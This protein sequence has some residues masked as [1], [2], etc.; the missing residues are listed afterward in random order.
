MNFHGIVGISA[1]ECIFATTGTKMSA[2]DSRSAGLRFRC[3]CNKLMCINGVRNRTGE[4]LFWRKF[5]AMKIHFI[6]IGGSAMHNLA[7]ALSREGHEVSGSDDEIFEPSKGRLAREGILPEKVGWDP[8]RIH[9]GLDAVILGM[10]ARADNPELAKAKEL[11]IPIYSYPE[12]VFRQTQDQTRVVIGGSHGKTTITA[13][14][15][16]V[17][18]KTG[19]DTNYLVGAQ[20]EGYDCMIRLSR[21]APVAIIEGDEY[22]TSPIDRRPKF[23]LYKPHIALLS[24]IA[25]DHINVFPTE[26]IYKEQFRQFIDLIE[27]DGSLVYFEGDTVLSELAAGARGDV[28]LIPYGEPDYFVKEGVTVVRYDDREFPLALLGRHNMQNLAGAM[29]V[30]GELGIGEEEFLHAI[31]DFTGASNRLQRLSAGTD[32]AVY[33]DFAHAP[34]KLRAT[35]SA[36]KAQFPDRRLVA[37][38]ELHTFSSLNKDFLPQYRHAME[39]ADRAMVYFSPGVVAHKKLP[40]LSTDDVRHAFDPDH[41][42]RIEVY[43]DSSALVADLENEDWAGSNLLLMSSGNFDGIDLKKLVRKVEGGE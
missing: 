18:K 7:I 19:R 36:L 1:V 9:P 3:E 26:E 14:L 41:P 40:P 21:G 31:S 8:Q 33:K 43:T 12:Y 30:A 24:G 2:A 37:C 11:G 16:H 23:H 20:L 6:A 29:A 15:L 4:H 38:M 5:T 22:L 42:N 27:P 39:A 35:T 34:S 10:H 17:M 13:M 32:R 25:W 28:A